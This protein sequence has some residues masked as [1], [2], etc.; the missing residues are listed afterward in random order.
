[1]KHFRAYTY[2]DFV[3]YY[4]PKSSEAFHLHPVEY[5][6]IFKYIKNIGSR[7]DC[8]DAW[9]RCVASPFNVAAK[10]DLSSTHGQISAKLLPEHCLCPN[11]TQSRTRL[12]FLSSDQQRLPTPLLMYFSPR[13]I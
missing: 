10:I 12:H 9:S 2:A 6:Y 13:L 7:G 5:E 11:P 1:M 4:L 3:P 8:T